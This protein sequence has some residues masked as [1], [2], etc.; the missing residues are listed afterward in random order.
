MKSDNVFWELQRT[1][2]AELTKW[3]LTHPEMEAQIPN[4]ALITFNIKGHTDFNVWSKK[5]GKDQ[6]EPNQP[7]IVV[8]IDELAPPLGS[9]LV[10]PHVEVV[11]K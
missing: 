6:R 2:S 4:N 7:V 1:L 5:I 11:S 10:N 3:L 8:E 9:R